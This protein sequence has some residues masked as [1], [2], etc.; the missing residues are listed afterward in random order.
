MKKQLVGIIVTAI[1]A[2]NM[3]M[4]AFATETDTSATSASIPSTVS[5]E[6]EQKGG[7]SLPESLQAQPRI[8]NSYTVY[9]VGTEWKKVCSD[10]P[11]LGQYVYGRISLVGQNSTA[12]RFQ[13]KLVTAWD[14]ERTINA[15]SEWREVGSCTGT[16]SSW[17]MYVRATSGTADITVHVKD[18]FGDKWQ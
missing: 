18:Q 9:N 16:V 8:N 15:S 5:L 3:G 13:L 2:G 7:Q 6:H 17:T 12:D 10:H 14:N 1:L 11:I 4:V